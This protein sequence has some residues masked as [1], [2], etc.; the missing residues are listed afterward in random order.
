MELSYKNRKLEKSFTTD[1]GLYRTYG[2]LAKKIKQRRIQLKSANNLLVISKLPVLRLHQY[3]GDRK[4][5]WSI[6]I[7]ENWRILFQINQK[8]IPTF[9]DGGIDLKAITI[10]SI[11]SVEDPH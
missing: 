10:I 7:Q 9:E 1:T 11:E 4:G 5:I 2:K 6:D 3:K 8:P